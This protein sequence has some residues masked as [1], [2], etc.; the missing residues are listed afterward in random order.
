MW[1]F[2]GKSVGCGVIL[3]QDDSDPMARCVARVAWRYIK[4]GMVKPG[5]FATPAYCC[6]AAVCCCCTV[7][8]P[9][10]RLA[11]PLSVMSNQ[12]FVVR[13]TMCSFFVVAWTSTRVQTIIPSCSISANS[14]SCT[15]LVFC[16]YSK[17]FA[18]IQTQISVDWLKHC[19]ITKAFGRSFRN[20]DMI[21]YVSANT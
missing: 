19:G 18:F 21:I 20:P 13:L 7:C 8:K 2:S 11:W 12:K 6:Y 14:M 9:S 3:N 1:F 17:A 10:G 5:M 16:M 4:T 15:C